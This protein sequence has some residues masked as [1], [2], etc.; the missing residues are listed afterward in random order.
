MDDP[1]L[2]AAEH[3]RA[4]RGLRR[5]N[6]WSGAASFMWKA[7]RSILPLGD[8]GPIRILDVACGSGDL[9]VA[10]A[11]RAHRDGINVAWFG[12]DISP[13]AV[14]QAGAAA[15]AAEVC[16][17]C[18]VHDAVRDPLPDRYDFVTSALF[19]HHLDEDDAVTLMRRLSAA[20]S[21]SVLI[22]DLERSYRG[23]ALA[24]AACRVLTRSPVVRF[25]GPASV[26]GAYTVAEAIRLAE[27]ANLDAV[28][29][30]RHWPCRFLLRADVLSRDAPGTP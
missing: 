22:D 28:R 11:R 20:A 4:L 25:D 23:Y 26:A 9:T 16:S 29:V 27:R 19:L 1:A 21:R 30:T 13:F 5:I 3:S 10:M 8:S 7:I 6:R 17:T 18:F 12:C 15:S 2:P 14:Q 24:W